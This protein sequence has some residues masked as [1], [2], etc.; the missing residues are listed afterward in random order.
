MS[1][2]DRDRLIDARDHAGHAIEHHGHSS[3]DDL[4][5]ARALRQALLFD[6][7]VI[8][9]ALHHASSEVNRLSQ[10]VPWQATWNMRNRLIHGYWNIDLGLVHEVLVHDLPR[11][12]DA[13]DRLI[14]LLERN[15]S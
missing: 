8:G 14:E 9:E 5:R 15:S 3:D 1:R 2:S 11:L 6:L 13:L 7:L 12:T 10:D 4:R